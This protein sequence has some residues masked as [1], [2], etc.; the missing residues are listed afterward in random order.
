LFGKWPEPGAEGV[1]IMD[2]AVQLGISSL[3]NILISL[4]SIVIC[5][6]VIMGLRL[7]EVIKPGRV[8]Q[9]RMLAII[10]SIVLGHQL[11]SFLI[12]YLSWSRW[13][14]GLFA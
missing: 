8:V 11:A 12:D 13:I 9:A 1:H 3:V 10:L 6:W 7:E 5:W 4:A 14:S 2:G